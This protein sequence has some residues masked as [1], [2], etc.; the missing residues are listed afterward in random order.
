MYQPEPFA[1][2]SNI[3]TA[4]NV[5]NVDMNTWYYPGKRVKSNTVTEAKNGGTACTEYDA[6]AYKKADAVNAVCRPDITDDVYQFETNA[7]QGWSL[8][9]NGTP[10]TI[11]H[12]NSNACVHPSGGELNPAD[13]TNAVWYN[14]GCGE[15][16]TQFAYDPNSKLIRHVPSGK[17]LRVYRDGTNNGDRIGFAPCNQYQ[18]FSF[19]GGVLKHLPSGKCIHP[20]GGSSTPGNG[21]NLVIYDCENNLAKIGVK[22]KMV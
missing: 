2:S 12:T 5:A 18:Q 8:K 16:V 19:E 3:V 10:F 6:V 13:D 14:G 11:R 17:C 15:P 21:T 9:P 7:T 22:A 20:E 4:S 1:L